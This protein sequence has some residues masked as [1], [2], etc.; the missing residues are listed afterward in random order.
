M[1]S[2]HQNSEKDNSNVESQPDQSAEVIQPV[3]EELEDDNLE[4]ED[5]EYLDDDEEEEEEYE[6]SYRYLALWQYAQSISPVAETYENSASGTEETANSET[7]IIQYHWTYDDLEPYNQGV[8]HCI[9]NWETYSGLDDFLEMQYP[10]AIHTVLSDFFEEKF[11]SMWENLESSQ[12]NEFINLNGGPDRFIA[13]RNW[14]DSD[15]FWCEKF[16]EAETLTRCKH[17]NCVQDLTEEEYSRAHDAMSYGSSIEMS[18]FETED[19]GLPSG[20]KN[21]LTLWWINVSNV[22]VTGMGTDKEIGDLLGPYTSYASAYDIFYTI[23][24]KVVED[25]YDIQ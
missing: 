10:K 23:A 21:R 5:D 22:T 1:Q 2:S 17:I 13:E 24:R 19:D 11:H 15:W 3:V 8:V 18:I 9:P 6:G 20:V 25:K 16:A 4:E 12:K 7:Q 14:G